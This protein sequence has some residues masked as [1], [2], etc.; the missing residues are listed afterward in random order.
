M[1]DP[2]LDYFAKELYTTESPLKA[3]KTAEVKIELS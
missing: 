3:R 1:T 2:H